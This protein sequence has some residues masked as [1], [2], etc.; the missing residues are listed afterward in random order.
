MLVEGAFELLVPR[1][2]LYERLLDARLLL[3]TSDGCLGQ[4]ALRMS[5][6]L[7][8][9]GH[10]LPSEKQLAHRAKMKTCSNDAGEKKLKG[11]DRKQ[12]MSTCLKG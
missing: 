2:L 4:H 5:R 11:E 10:S 3:L 7:L 12:F 1:A 8:Q 6:L 9:L